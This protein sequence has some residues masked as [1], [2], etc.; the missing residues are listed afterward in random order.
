MAWLGLVLLAPGQIQSLV[1]MLPAHTTE[2]W[3]R[4]LK[5]LLPFGSSAR[6]CRPNEAKD[7]IAEKTRATEANDLAND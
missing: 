2:C 4:T 1:S 3:R 7:F 6:V 5:Q